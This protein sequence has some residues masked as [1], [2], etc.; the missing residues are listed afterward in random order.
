MFWT[1]IVCLVL[2]DIGILQSVEIPKTLVN[3]VVSLDKIIR[4]EHG[5]VMIKLQRSLLN[6]DVKRQLNLKLNVHIDT[7]GVALIV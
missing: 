5:C 7:C 2:L 3:M 4:I 6:V 1:L